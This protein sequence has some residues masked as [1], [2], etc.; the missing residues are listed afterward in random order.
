M[1]WG[2]SFGCFVYDS[3]AALTAGRCSKGKRPVADFTGYGDSEGSIGDHATAA[4]QRLTGPLP[5]PTTYDLITLIG[6]A[7][8]LEEHATGGND[9]IEG[10]LFGNTT[11]LIGDARQMADHAQGGDDLIS[12]NFGFWNTIY[13]DAETMAG[14]AKGGNDTVAASAP[15][16]T[17]VTADS[18]VFGDARILSGH[19]E[20]GDDVLIGA[21]GFFGSTARLYGDGY[22]LRDHAKGGNDRLESRTANADEMWGDAYTVGKHAETGADVFVFAP[23][24]GRDI[25]HDFEQGKDRIDLTAFADSGIDDFEDVLARTIVQPDGTLVI[26][27]VDGLTGNSIMVA[28][29]SSL[30]VNDFIL[31]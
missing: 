17:R 31:G 16:G 15:Q 6:D 23:G 8:T 30:T 1:V 18:D 14:H 10:V 7:E 24:N 11:L 12:S 20:G 22:E 28:G 25:I 4:N 3:P 19:A 13:G 9:T 27:D 21:V 26:L 29:L 5:G 2:I